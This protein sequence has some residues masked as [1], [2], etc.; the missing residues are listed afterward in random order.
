MRTLRIQPAIQLS[1]SFQGVETPTEERWWELPE[2]TRQQILV[3]L[4][5]LIASG[6]IEEEGTKQ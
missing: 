1:M 4:A 2:K 6:I 3:L 5:R